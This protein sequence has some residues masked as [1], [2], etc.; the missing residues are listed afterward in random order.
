V[1]LTNSEKQNEYKHNHD[2]TI[3]RVRIRQIAGERTF[4]LEVILN[5]E[6]E[7]KIL[8]RRSECIGELYSNEKAKHH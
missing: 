7:K 1:V 2:I 3:M 8:K 4:K 5:Q 6:N